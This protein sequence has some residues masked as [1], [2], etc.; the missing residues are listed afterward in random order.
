[1][2]KIIDIM[3]EAYPAQKEEEEQA[4]QITIN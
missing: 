3:R 4:I 1:M 2:N